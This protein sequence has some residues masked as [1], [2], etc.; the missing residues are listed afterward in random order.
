MARVELPE[1]RLRAR[2]RRRRWRILLLVVIML[3]LLVGAVVAAAYIPA[4][5][6]RT[7]SVLGAQTLS[8][9]TIAVAVRT[10][11]DGTYGYVLP[12]DNIFLYPKRD[13]TELLLRTYPVLASAQ[14]HAANFHS[15]G[16]TVVERQPRALWCPST[17]S[18][19]ARCHFMDEQ[20]IVYAEAPSFSEPVYLSYFGVASGTPLTRDLPWQYLEPGEFQ[21]L[22][23]LVDAF[24]QQ[25]PQEELVSVEVDAQGDVRVR[26]ASASPAGGQGFMLIFALRDQGGDVFER[27]VLTLG[28]APF[29]GKELSSFEYLDLRFG[30]KLYYKLR[31]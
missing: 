25:L 10:K 13:I 20:G 22:S 23:A 7:I 2:K 14:V 24:V 21:P 6:I 30:D 27:L 17:S 15:L 19:Q 16:V 29:A 3:A 12:K 5:R 31:D 18:G 4:I 26:F 9:T 8:S 28:H 11:L 1:S